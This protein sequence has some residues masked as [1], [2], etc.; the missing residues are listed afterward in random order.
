MKMTVTGKW[1]GYLSRLDKKVH[2]CMLI[3]KGMFLI[4]DKNVGL[5]LYMKNDKTKSHI[6][7]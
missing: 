2:I 5:C 7:W 4:M 1:A 3:T 6:I